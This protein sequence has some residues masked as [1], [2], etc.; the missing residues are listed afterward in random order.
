MYSKPLGLIDLGAFCHCVIVTG[1]VDRGLL[2]GLNE[3]H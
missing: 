3:L 1:K 2:V